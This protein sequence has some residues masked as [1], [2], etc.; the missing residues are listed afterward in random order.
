MAYIDETLRASLETRTSDQAV[1]V[2]TSGADPT[3]ATS[4]TAAIQRAINSAIEGATSRAVV[5]LGAG[6]YLVGALWHTS[7]VS[8][9]GQG[10]SA[11]IL[12]SDGVG[13]E[14]GYIDVSSATT[15][16]TAGDMLSGAT[17]GATAEYLGHYMLTGSWNCS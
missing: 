6:T 16:P 11:S 2:A 17:S 10:A 9:R 4:S 5:E 7:K 14:Y 3:G 1:H 8:F 15:E 12:Q 13:A